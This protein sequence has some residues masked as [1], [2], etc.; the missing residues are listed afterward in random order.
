MLPYANKIK[1]KVPSFA[2]FNFRFCKKNSLKIY[3]KAF[4]RIYIIST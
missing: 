4:I 3:F 1:P 2:T